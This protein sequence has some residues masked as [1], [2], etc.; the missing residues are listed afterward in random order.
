MSTNGDTHLGGDDFDQ[1]IVDWI[2]DEFKKAESIDLKKDAMALQRLRDAA[3]KAKCELSSSKQTDI[4]LP[5]I[6][7]DSNGPKHMNLNLTRAKFESLASELFSRMETPCLTALN[8]AKINKEDI[9]DI[10]LVGG[11]TRIPK[12]QDL[13]ED[14]FGKTPN[15]SV[16]PD[17]VVALGAAIQGG[18]MSGDADEIVLLDLTPLSLGIETLGGVSTKIIEANSTIPCKKSQVFSTAADNQPAVDINIHQGEREMASDNKSLDRFILD[19]I[20][21]AP[22]GT[23]QIEVVFDIDSNGILNVSATDKATGKVQSISIEASGALNKDEIQKMKDEAEANAESDK[24]K[25]DEIDTRNSGEQL[26]YQTD[27]QLKELADKISD[28]H[29]TTIT[30]KKEDLEST[31][32]DGDTDS[33]K[34]K[35]EDLNKAWSDI[36]QQMSSQEQSGETGPQAKSGSS[37]NPFKDAASSATSKNEE[38]VE[39]ADFEVVDKDETEK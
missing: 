20:P 1:M 28:E 2:I 6:T 8:D 4:N 10:I 24:M 16:N 17:E 37:A 34:L 19:G 26:L 23:P 14:I 21:P 12:V 32:K 27:S 31:L 35:I 9:R 15:K 30:S 11:S 38:N 5:F 22:R 33:I 25:R 36:Y 29:K 3:E 7:A 13:V 18:V 39:D